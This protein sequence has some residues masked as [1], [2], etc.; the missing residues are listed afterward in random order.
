MQ[1]VVQRVTQSS[2]T[3]A[4]QAVSAIGKGLLVLLGVARDDSEKEADWLAEKI[5]HLRIFE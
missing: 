5:I 2:V 1:A 4:D 3:V